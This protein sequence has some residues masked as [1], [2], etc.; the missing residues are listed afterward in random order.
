MRKRKYYFNR[1]F[2]KNMTKKQIKYMLE[3]EVFSKDKFK[4]HVLETSHKTKIDI[5]IVEKVLKNYI[6]NV[7][8]VINTVR[9][10]KTKINIYGFFSLIVEKGKN[11]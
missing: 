9:K 11:I 3:R 7:V 2:F 5:V 4:Q 10:I 6:F 1:G 8:L